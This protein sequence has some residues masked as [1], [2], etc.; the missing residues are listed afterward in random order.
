MKTKLYSIAIA[1]VA[2]F[3]S[4]SDEWTPNMENDG[5]GHLA[6]SDINVINSENLIGS[7]S[8]DVSG[9]I[10]SVSDSKGAV[11]SQWVYGQMPESVTLPV[12]TGYTAKVISHNQQK[13]AW[14]APYFEGVS[15]PFDIVKDK[16]TEPGAINCKL[17]NIK[18]SVRFSDGL[19]KAMSDDC[20]VTV[21]ANDEGLLEYTP[22]ETRTGYFAAVEGSTTFIATFTGTVN[23]NYVEIQRAYT[24]A[25]PGQHRVISYKLTPDGE[26][27]S[28]ITV[29]MTTVDE[30]IE[31]NVYPGEGDDDDHPGDE[32]PDNPDDPDEFISVTSST[33]DISKVNEPVDGQLYIVDIVSKNPIAHLKVKIIS[34]GLTPEILEAVG[35][36]AEF[37]LAE[38]GNLEE[39]LRGLGFPVGPEVS[40][41]NSVTFDITLF[42]PLLGG[43]SGDHAFE[44]TITDNAGNEK[45]ATLRFHA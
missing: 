40:G 25:A 14:D 2:L 12:G 44:L 21:T 43:F 7:A 29:K 39:A 34:D 3:A 18:V 45:V 4:C 28:G 41:Q 17:S 6:K 27:S 10:V 42:V 32:D 22:D 31:G 8:A 5:D 33:F 13:A 20:K 30:S 37:D 1:A 26:A 24:D 35:L 36:K 38:P 19:K 23:G 16:V 15:E 9:F 11:V